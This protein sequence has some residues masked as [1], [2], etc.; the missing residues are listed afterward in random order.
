MCIFRYFPE[1]G[2][3]ADGIKKALLA[4]DKDVKDA[5]RR[6]KQEIERELKDVDIKVKVDT[7]AAEAQ[8]TTLRRAIRPP[9]KPLPTPRQRKRNTM[10]RHA[11]ARPPSTLTSTRTTSAGWVCRPSDVRPGRQS[12]RADRDVWGHDRTLRAG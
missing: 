1:T 2:K 5:A 3:I 7:A 10:R 11:T 12:R 4:A 9:S 8:L 6:W